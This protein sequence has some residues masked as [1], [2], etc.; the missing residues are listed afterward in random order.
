MSLGQLQQRAL[1]TT[2][3]QAFRN[4]DTGAPLLRSPKP[5]TPLLL[6]LIKWMMGG[7]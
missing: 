6:R 4:G 2:N 7:K 1:R 3:R 5:T